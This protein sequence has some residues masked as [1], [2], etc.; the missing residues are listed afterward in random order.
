MKMYHYFEKNTNNNVQ[1]DKI[2]DETSYLQAKT[3]SMATNT[4]IQQSILAAHLSSLNK[5]ELLKIANN[6]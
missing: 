4:N 6:L 1:I 5:S 3:F 2:N